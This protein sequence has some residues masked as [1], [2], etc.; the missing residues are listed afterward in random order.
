MEEDVDLLRESMHVTRGCLIVP[1]Q[2]D[3]YDDV[4][5]RI[6]KDILEEVYRTGIRGVIIDASGVDVID[7]FAARAIADTA[8]MVSL[9]GAKTLITG[10][11][12]GVASSLVGLDFEFKDIQTALSLDEGLNMVRPMAD[13][14]EDKEENETGDDFDENEEGEKVEEKPSGSG[15]EEV[16]RG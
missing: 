15:N 14:G 2:S 12:S 8:K 10:I 1:L 11:K 7:R 5:P 13:S 3:L 4:I 6:Q 16:S 9:L